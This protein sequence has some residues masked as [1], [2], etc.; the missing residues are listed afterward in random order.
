MQADAERSEHVDVVGWSRHAISRTHAKPGSRRGHVSR[1]H[2]MR[3]TGGR[4]LRL[5]CVAA[6]P[7]ATT[8]LA[9]S[10]QFAW[11]RQVTALRMQKTERWMLPP[12]RRRGCGQGPPECVAGFR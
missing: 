10:W 5:I 4:Y 7:R 2:R 3:R 1:S 6:T 9:R 12:H 11:S 8:L